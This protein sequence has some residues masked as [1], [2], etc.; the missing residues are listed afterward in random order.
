MFYATVTVD[1]N[2][3]EPIIDFVDPSTL[4]CKT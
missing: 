2:V 4:D 1:F 3:E